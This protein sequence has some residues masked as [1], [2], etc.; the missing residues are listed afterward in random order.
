M[1]PKKAVQRTSETRITEILH[2]E[3]KE[4]NLPQEKKQVILA[5]MS[6]AKKNRSFWN[7]LL[8]MME[9]EVEISLEP[10][11]H[12]KR[13]NER[14]YSLFPITLSLCI[15]I[16]TLTFPY[17]VIQA[18]NDRVVTVGSAQIICKGGGN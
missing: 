15:L 10:M 9:Y 7:K 2:T 4:L 1:E 5:V 12:K 11:F 17:G 6:Q 3:L 18:K 8:D 13:E 14:V 16:L